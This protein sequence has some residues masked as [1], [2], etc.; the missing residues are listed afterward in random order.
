[1]ILA[2]AAT[3]LEMKPFIA[4]AKARSLSCRTLVTGVGPVETTLRLT[5]FLCE[6][7]EQFDA[8]CLFGIGGAYVQPDQRCQAALLDI[9]LAEKEVSGDFG[10]CFGDVMEYLDSSLVGEVVYQMDESLR[11]RCRTVFDRLEIEHRRGVF[12]T[13]NGITGNAIRGEMLRARWNGLC[14]NMEGAAVARVCC[15]FILPCAEIRC[16]SNYVE[17]RDPRTWRLQEACMKSAHTAVQLIEA[18]TIPHGK[19]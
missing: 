4:E 7:N 9:C 16:I 17:D 15:D 10:I 19:L 11:N 13:V 8:V 3:E 2:L 12:I 18:M 6:S 14:E 5:R 1:M